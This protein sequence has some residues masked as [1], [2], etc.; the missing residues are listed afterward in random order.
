[1]LVQSITSAS[2]G[3]VV[4]QWWYSDWFV[5]GEYRLKPNGMR[6]PFHFT[7]LYILSFGDA[8]ILHVPT[9]VSTPSHPCVKLKALVVS[10]VAA[11]MVQ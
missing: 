5:N 10:P 11:V 2:D 9:S 8:V 6:L 3:T 7:A 1:M 4:A